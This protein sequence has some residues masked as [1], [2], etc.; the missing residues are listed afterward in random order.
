VCVYAR[1]NKGR[2]LVQVLEEFGASAR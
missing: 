1:L 2:A